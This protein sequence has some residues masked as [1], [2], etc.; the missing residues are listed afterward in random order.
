MSIL[1][2]VTEDF[3]MI[4]ECCHQVLDGN[5]TEIIFHQNFEDNS[6][7]SNGVAYYFHK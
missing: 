7:S 2:L 6:S 4:G 3:R 5:V 1:T